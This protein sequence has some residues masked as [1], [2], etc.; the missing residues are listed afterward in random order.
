MT[1][2]T[3]FVTFLRVSFGC[4]LED[5]D[6]AGT[7]VRL[8]VPSDADLED[9]GTWEDIASRACVAWGGALWQVAHFE[10]NGCTDPDCCGTRQ[11]LVPGLTVADVDSS[12]LMVELPL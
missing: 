6:Y 9:R 10:A 7:G 5:L 4:Y 2:L 1:T 11:T 3:L 12:P 8:F